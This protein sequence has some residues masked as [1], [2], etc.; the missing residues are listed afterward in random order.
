MEMKGM[1]Y[2]VKK[3]MRI[4][5]SM[6]LLL[7]GAS[8]HLQAQKPVENKCIIKDG[9]I[10]ITL[11]KQ[12]DEKTLDSFIAR[13]NLEDL[14]LKDLLKHNSSDMLQQQGWT[15]NRD[16]NEW[17]GISKTLFSL[18]GLENP[19]DKIM[20]TEKHPSV[21]ER[22]PA[23]NNGTRFGYNRFKN[24]A[25]FYRNDS[26]VSFYLRNHQ[27][28]KQ[29]YLA[30][31]FSNWQPT[32]IAMTHTD[33]G[34]VASVKLGPGKYWYKFVIDGNWETDADNLLKENDGEG[35]TNSVYF[36]PN[37]VFALN[38]YQDTKKVYLAGSF[39]D[40]APK[41]LPMNKT[42]G[43][44]ELPLYLPEGTHT[45]RFVADGKWFADPANNDQLPNEFSKYNS[46]IRIGNTHLFK[47]DGYLDAKSVVL[48]GSFN[49]W[50][51]Y[52]LPMT[53]TATG[54]ELPYVLGNGNYEYKF[55]VDGKYVLDPAN[56]L[57]TSAGN[58]RQG[59]SYLI[60]NPNYT[61]RL[62][63]YANASKAYVSGDFDNWSPNTLQ[64]IK[65]GE[66]WVF[67]V[68]LSIGKHLYKFLVDGKWITDPGNKLWEQ[69]EY[70]TGNSVLWIE[71]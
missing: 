46:V 6:A 33:S 32:G 39:N 41:Q 49:S 38:G 63:G 69:N 7:L 68:H 61:F 1:I 23:E 5:C 10:F 52:E 51:Q 53:K 47:L 25:P 3:L 16:G 14:Q 24:K 36:R 22:F 21:S 43:G 9:K 48:A 45:Y 15:I 28:A 54:W 18:N 50:H 56:P 27:D 30:G 8:I 65:D 58:N 13:F 40:W 35:N 37:Y 11:A 34:W 12:Q 44:W 70:S 64:M 67:S 4:Y 57:I 60:I 17:M 20:A 59:N 55:L 2:T 29:V 42:T 19:A 62:K 71:K 26:L 66:D 31:S